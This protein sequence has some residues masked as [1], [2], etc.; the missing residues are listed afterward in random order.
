MPEQLQITYKKSAIGRVFKQKRGIRALGFTH[1]GQSRVVADNP[2]M[3]GMIRKVQ[4][5][6][7]VESLSESVVAPESKKSSEVVEE[8]TKD[9]SVTEVKEEEPSEAENNQDV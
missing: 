1:L 2:A 5:L 3:R 9:T 8:P 7:V 4:H 6:L